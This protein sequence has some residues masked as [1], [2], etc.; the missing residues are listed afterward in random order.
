MRIAIVDDE[1]VD[2][3][4]AKTYL[5]RYLEMRCPDVARRMAIDSFHGGD[6]LLSAF[7]PGKYDLLV[8]DIRMD[9]MSGIDLA[10]LIREQD[11]DVSIVFLT[12]SEDYLLEGYRVFAVGYFLKP[13]AKNAEAFA[14]TFEHIFPRIARQEQV[15]AAKVE[16]TRIDVPYRQICYVDIGENHRPCIHLPERDIVT[17]M[18]F[19]DFLPLLSEQRFMECHYRIIINMAFIQSMKQDDFV[20]RTGHTV[21]ISRRM[22]KEAKARY[23]S[24]L[25]HRRETP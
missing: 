25:A 14:R 6:E 3:L 17:S 5:C 18:A 1:P 16:G 13:L 8:L 24:Y 21:P 2:L 12:S 20:L 15:L 10:K 11:S 19:D 7:R 23:M 4:T 22:K 9:D